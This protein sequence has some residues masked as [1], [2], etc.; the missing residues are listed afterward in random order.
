MGGP[1]LL[2]DA[3]NYFI[4]KLLLATRILLETSF[5]GGVIQIASHFTLWNKR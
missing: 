5:A 1:S 4:L 2:M 3:M